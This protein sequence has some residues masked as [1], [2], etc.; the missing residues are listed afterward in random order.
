MEL[1][2]RFKQK[3]AVLFAYLD[4]RQRRIAA[5]LEARSLGH[6]GVTAVAK[7]TGMSRPS[8]H[9]GLGELTQRKPGV[10]LGRSRKPGAGRKPV[11]DRDPE[12]V[13]QLDRLVDPDTRGDP[14]PPL[15]WTCKST[16][17]L[18]QALTEAGHPV[19]H[20]VVGELLGSMGYSLQ[21]NVKTKEGASHPDRDARFPPEARPPGPTRERRPRT[22]RRRAGTRASGRPRPPPPPPR[23]GA[24]VLPPTSPPSIP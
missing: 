6:G 24:P 1:H 18:A 15:R 4:E 14:M 20:G 16:R 7:A 22:T 13:Q 3:F 11:T 12:I 2:E 8:I 19:S 5:A 9:R 10:P 21:A 17:Q 23:R